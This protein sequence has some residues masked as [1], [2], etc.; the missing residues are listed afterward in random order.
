MALENVE[1]EIGRSA[2]EKVKAIVAETNAEIAAIKAEA[3]AEISAIEEREKKRL[4]ETLAR[5]RRQEVSSAE[6][7]SKKI[8][9]AKKNEILNETFRETLAELEAAP[10]AEKLEQYKKMVSA[11][12]KA[13]GKPI[14]HMSDKDA[15]TATSLGAAKVVKDAGISGGL[16]LESADGTMQI[17]M[18]YETILRQ[19]WDRELK[20]LS[21][22]LL[23]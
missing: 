8:V 16:I 10:K 20:G 22:I 4:N 11:A 6:L 18:R 12:T 17:D 7:E 23:G 13:I 21:D 19:V 9:L 15:F 5:L 1:A 14:A 2:E 3:D